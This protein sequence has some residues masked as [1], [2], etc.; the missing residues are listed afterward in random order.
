MYTRLK[1][2]VFNQNDQFSLL[3]SQ[4]LEKKH[5]PLHTRSTNSNVFPL[6]HHQVL[7]HSTVV[8]SQGEMNK[9]TSFIYVIT[10]HAHFAFI[11]A[12]RSELV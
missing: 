11:G 1:T 10:R 2:A 12:E 6:K 4:S 5:G 9:F 3:T 7:L 8:C